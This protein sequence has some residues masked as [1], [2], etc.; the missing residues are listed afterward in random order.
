MA[1]IAMRPLAAEKDLDT[2]KAEKLQRILA[3]ADR[4]SVVIKAGYSTIEQESWPKQEAEAKVLLV[5]ELA[6]APLLRGI[7]QNRGI[8]L[9]VLRD[10][11]LANVTLAE[12]ASGVIL[13]KQQALEDQVKAATTVEEVQSIDASITLG[14]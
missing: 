13:G 10:K 2:L 14:G 3:A 12:T 9:L 8:D 5:D 6:A 11:V 7:A 1:R 4:A